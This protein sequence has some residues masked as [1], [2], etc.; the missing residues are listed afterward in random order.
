MLF[1]EVENHFE[2]AALL[3]QID[4]QQFWVLIYVSKVPIIDWLMISSSS[5]VTSPSALSLA[6]SRRSSIG[7]DDHLSTFINRDPFI[8]SSNTFVENKAK[9]LALTYPSYSNSQGILV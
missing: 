1:R 4:I 3:R 8:G 2:I 6:S 5:A 7:Q 9:N